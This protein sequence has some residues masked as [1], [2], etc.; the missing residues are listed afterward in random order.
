MPVQAARHA[1]PKGKNDSRPFVLGT[2]GKRP[3][4]I[5]AVR[6]NASAD[7]L[8]GH[9]DSWQREPYSYCKVNKADFVSGH[10]GGTTGCD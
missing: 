4:T 10:S 9:G 3:V 7:D 6:T 8:T 5:L 1:A 2:E